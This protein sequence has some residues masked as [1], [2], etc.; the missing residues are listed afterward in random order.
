[1]SPKIIL[2]VVLFAAALS[3]AVTLA[4]IEGGI[5]YRTVPDL[6][7]GS[8]SG[9]R[10]KLKGQILE[11]HQD[12]KPARFTVADIPESG[13]AAANGPACM[14]IYEGDDVPQ[15]LKRAAHVT[16]EGRY[17][18]AKGAFIATLVQTQCPSRYDGQ[19]LP[20]PDTAP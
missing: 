5:E 12:F 15:G 2:V 1:M 6:V 7:S 4:L 3:G 18:R 19:Q 17:D 9:Q 10:V 11:V 16:I 13:R 14:V 20:P 8:Y